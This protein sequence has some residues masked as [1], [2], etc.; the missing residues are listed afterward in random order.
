MF[1]KGSATQEK[2]LQSVDTHSPS[3]WS[4]GGVFHL[5]PLH[6]STFGCEPVRVLQRNNPFFKESSHTIMKV[7]PKTY[8]RFGKSPNQQTDPVPVW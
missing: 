3:L 4:S 5:F 6:L 2:L 1:S 8:K 7:S